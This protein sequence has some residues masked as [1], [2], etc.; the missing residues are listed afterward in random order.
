MLQLADFKIHEYKRTKKTIV[1]DQIYKV[2]IFLDSDPL[3]TAY[4]GESLPQFKKE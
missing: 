3:L 4:K 1:E 2:M